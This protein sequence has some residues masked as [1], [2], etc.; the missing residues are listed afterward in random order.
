MDRNQIRTKKDNINDAKVRAL[1]KKHKVTNSRAPLDITA[2]TLI[3]RSHNYHDETG[4]RESLSRSYLC[5]EHDPLELDD[6]DLVR[7]KMDFLS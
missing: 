7:L 1:S 6:D 4:K 3:V 5:L 2:I